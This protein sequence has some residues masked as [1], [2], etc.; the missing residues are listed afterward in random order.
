MTEDERFGSH[1]PLNGHEFELALGVMMDREDW[2]AAVH[3]V[4][5]NRTRLSD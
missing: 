3:E 1:H 4:A 5:K 2:R